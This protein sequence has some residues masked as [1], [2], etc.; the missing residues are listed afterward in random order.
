[1]ERRQFFG[2]VGGLVMWPLAARAASVI[3]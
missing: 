1:M 3:E 2:L